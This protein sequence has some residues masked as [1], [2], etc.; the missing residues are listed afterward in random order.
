MSR[1]GAYQAA[2]ARYGTTIERAKSSIA[3]RIGGACTKD[4]LAPEVAAA[5]M[6][7]LRRLGA[8]A[9]AIDAKD[10]QLFVYLF[11]KSFQKDDLLL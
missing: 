4:P 3:P 1:I 5:L 11:G 6:R 9:E 8:E 7:D 2:A 10:G